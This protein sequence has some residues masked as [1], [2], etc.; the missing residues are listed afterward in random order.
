MCRCDARLDEARQQCVTCV[1]IDMNQPYW[2]AN[3]S[4][5]KPVPTTALWNNAEV[6]RPAVSLFGTQMRADAGPA[7]KTSPFS[8]RTSDSVKRA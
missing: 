6:S 5:V 3:T 4:S 2:N 1:E 8:M 7:H